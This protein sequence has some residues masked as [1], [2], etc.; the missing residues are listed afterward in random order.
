MSSYAIINLAGVQIKATPDARIRVPKM[1]AEVGTKISLDQVLL[2]SD[3]KKVQVGQPVISGVKVEA[4]IV[5]HGRERKI[6]VFKKK[7]RKDYRRT[8]GHRQ[9]F[10]EI[11]ITK[12]PK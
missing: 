11:R 12:F 1:E 2:L 7:R 5:L 6:I 10:T 9:H 3:G 4:E 8:N